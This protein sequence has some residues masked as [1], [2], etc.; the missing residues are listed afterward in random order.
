MLTLATP[1]DRETALAAEIGGLYR[2]DVLD[3]T[4]ADESHDGILD[5]LTQAYVLIVAHRMTEP[6]FGIV[7]AVMH[8]DGRVQR[9][10]IGTYAFTAEEAASKWSDVTGRTVTTAAL[11]AAGTPA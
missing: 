10:G 1:T 4:V 6:R 3:L 7:D 5:G 9:T 11:T 8:R 2:G